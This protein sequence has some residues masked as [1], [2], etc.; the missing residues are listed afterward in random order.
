MVS[1]QLRINFYAPGVDA[2]LHRPDVL[3]TVTLKIRG[4]IQTS[5]TVM[6][7]KNDFT[8]FRPLGH[9]LLHQLLSEKSGA[10]DVNS[11]PFF[12]TPDIDQGDLLARSQAFSDFRR[13]NL[14][15]LIGL[16]RR[17]NG[18]NDIL[19]WQIIIPSADSSQSFIRAKAA[20][21]A[22]TDMI[23]P[24]KGP[25][26]TWIL[27]KKLRHRCIGVDCSR[28][29]HVYQ[30]YIIS[31]ENQKNRRPDPVSFPR[32]NKYCAQGTLTERFPNLRWMP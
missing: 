24:E 5:D 26:S 2:A 23:G 19:Q 13:R 20:T 3:K 9:D 11:I 25:L 8:I 6:A 7:N 12:P 18:R 28:H 21:G 29:A 31:T 10:F 22:A 1:G 15:F 27:L 32:D 4:C 30:R 16:M 14:R 17:Q